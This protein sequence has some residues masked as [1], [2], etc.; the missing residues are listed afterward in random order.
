M[1]VNMYEMRS[2]RIKIAFLKKV[3]KKRKVCW[4]FAPRPYSLRHLGDPPPKPV[5]DAFELY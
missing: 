3:T 2:D 5:C 4:G 1:A